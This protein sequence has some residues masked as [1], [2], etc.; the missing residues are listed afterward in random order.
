M[1]RTDGG[2]AG[3]SSSS[4]ALECGM[5]DFASSPGGG[6][7]KVGNTAEFNE[8][9][10]EFIAL[11]NAHGGVPAINSGTPQNCGGTLRSGKRL[12]ID[13]TYLYPLQNAMRCNSAAYGGTPKFAKNGNSVLDTLPSS[14]ALSEHSNCGDHHNPAT[15]WRGSLSAASAAEY[16]LDNVFTAN[17]CTA[18]PS[19]HACNG[20]S[21]T[22]R[23]AL[24]YVTNNVYTARPS[25]YTA[26]ARPRRRA[27]QPMRLGQVREQQRVH[28]V[29]VWSHGNGAAKTAC[30]TTKYVTSNVCSACPFAHAC[31]GA[32]KTPSATTKYVTSNV[33]TAYPFAHTCNGAADAGDSLGYVS[34][35]VRATCPSGYTCDGHSK[36]QCATTKYVAD[37]VGTAYP[38][39]HTR[40]GTSK[41]PCDSHKYVNSNVAWR[42]Q[43]PR[44]PAADQHTNVAY[45]RGT[46][47]IRLFVRQWA[48]QVAN[49]EADTADRKARRSRRPDRA[50]GH[51]GSHHA[52]VRPAAHPHERG[53][54]DRGCGAIAPC[55]DDV[56]KKV[57]RPG[58]I[59]PQ[60]DG[61]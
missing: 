23:D 8:H 54:S 31:N 42:P 49:Q 45:G 24:K 59:H 33:C 21:K 48:L 25:G 28:G 17:V 58:D 57:R 50:K 6:W 47:G 61:F 35:D 51:D 29:S 7:D 12:Y 40:N 46:W 13:N 52:R 19:G 1:A 34:S 38:S 3:S 37:N 39:A 32:P 4:S 18:C 41:T 11:Y 16:V 22:P 27:P 14:N 56:W 15:Y 44:L 53:A 43:L 10:A 9:K 55:K 36:T 30:P 20:A 5:Y 60:A 26:A 2:Q